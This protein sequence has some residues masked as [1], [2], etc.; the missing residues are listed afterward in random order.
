MKRLISTLLIACSLFFCTF[1]ADSDEYDDGYIYS[2]NGS[3]DQILKI[4]LFGNFPL[5]FGKQ[6]YP[7]LGADL[8]YYKF[9]TDK[10]ALG[11]EVGI[12]NNFTIGSKALF[13]IPITAGVLYQPTIDHFEF[14]LSLNL[15]IGIETLQSSTYFPSLVAKFTGG[16]FMRLT[17]TWSFGVTTA[18]TWIPQW[19]KDSSKN[20]NGLFLNAGLS[21]RYHF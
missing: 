19:N 16:A 5:N 10:I 1:A 18:F 15:G 3:G 14:P 17:E 6:L 2:L 13:I 4:N 9:I 20:A 11:G 12:S 8:S 21:A 7:G